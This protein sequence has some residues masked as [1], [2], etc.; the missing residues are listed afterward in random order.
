MERDATLRVE[1]REEAGV[2]GTVIGLAG[3]L[4]FRPG[5]EDAL[6]EYILVSASHQGASREGRAFRWLSLEGA[7]ATFTFEETRALLRRAARR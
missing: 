2:T 4:F 3:T 1:L 5:S 6:V 7:L